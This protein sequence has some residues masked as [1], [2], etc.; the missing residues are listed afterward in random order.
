MSAKLEIVYRNPHDLHLDEMNPRIHPEALLTKLSASIQ[1]FGF[2]DP[3]LITE[4]DV[5]L[6]GHARIKTA[7]EDG[8]EKVP[9][10]VL[11]LS[12][13]DAIAYNIADNKIQDASEWDMP[14][15]NSNLE[16]LM[17]AGFDIQATGFSSSDIYRV[18]NDES[19]A[20]D[21]DN[22]K[23]I[24]KDTYEGVTAKMNASFLLGKYVVTPDAV[25]LD[26]KLEQIREPDSK[27]KEY[28]IALS[29][30]EAKFITDQISLYSATPELPASNHGF[31]E[32][33]L[34]SAKV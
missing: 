18:V 24:P 3:V 29:S 7:R 8:L 28:H 25:S 21:E 6:A 22:V 16:D 9:T 15:L 33:F 31:V 30:A 20:L 13:A 26:E 14:K 27:I 2:V 23:I 19:V 32:W 12:G 17:S 10:I 1:R 5:I 11:P 34:E 4:D